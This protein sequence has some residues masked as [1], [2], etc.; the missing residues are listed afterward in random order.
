MIKNVLWILAVVASSVAMAGDPALPGHHPLSQI[1]SGNLLL[2][3]LR[4]AACH[5]GVPRET[6]FEKSAPDLTKVGARVTP[7]F[8]RR[9]IESP[10]TAHPGTT[11]PDMLASKSA[12]EKQT[13]AE[14]LTH[15]LIAQ[16]QAAGPV[17]VAEP[18]DRQQGY[19]LFHSIGCVACHGPK[20]NGAKSP[21]RVDEEDEE[22]LDPAKAARKAIKPAVV[23]LGHVTAKYTTKSLSEFLFQPLKVRSS[24]RMPDMK[25][26]PTESLAIAGYLMGDP[27]PATQSLVP[28]RN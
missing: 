9:F 10:A 3:E 16:S 11:M 28:K 8:L 24:G 18:I 15:F 25:L 26:T 7:D 5:S 1:Q 4:C 13:I 27:G 2:A 21:S 12:S 17:E 23:G 20:E 14:S 22:E 19:E 6:R